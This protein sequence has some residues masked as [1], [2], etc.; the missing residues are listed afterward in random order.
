MKEISFDFLNDVQ[1]KEVS[2]TT[3]RN[4]LGILEKQPTGNCIRLFPDGK[5]FP[6]DELIESFDLNYRRKDAPVQG[7]G[8]DVFSVLDW[9]Q[10]PVDFNTPGFL[11]IAPVSKSEAKVDLFAHCRYDDQG[12]A[13]GNVATQGTST[14]GKHLIKLLKETYGEEF[15]DG[16]RV[17]LDLEIKNLDFP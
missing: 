1:L 11:V 5:V 8:F 9:G 3:T 17:Y 6:S 4:K 7:N 10:W 2:A 12:N 14:F 13:K 16:T 15:F